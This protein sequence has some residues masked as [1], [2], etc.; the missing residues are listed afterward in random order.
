MKMRKLHGEEFLAKHGVKLGF[1]STF[2]AGV[3]QALKDQ[4]AVNAVIDGKEMVY[5]DYCDITIAVASPTGLVTPVLRNCE[6]K[7][8]A[9]IEKEII[10]F[11]KKAKDGKMA[12]ED[13]AGGTFTISNGGVFKNY[14]GT[15]IINPGQ[16]AVL[17]MHG[18]VDRPVAINGE[19]KI[20]PM[21][22]VA[23]TYDHRIVD[24]REAAFFLRK[25]KECVEDPVR[26]CLDL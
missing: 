21:M 13:M 16:S 2:V 24:G 25:V 20:R 9:D 18:T 26:L 1:M 12:L 19:V 5:K 14:F 11:G 22:Y 23:L 8:M 7:S 6:T 10:Y 15:P 4:P 17:G 3:V